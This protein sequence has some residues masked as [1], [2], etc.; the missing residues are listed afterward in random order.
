MSN[1]SKEVYITFNEPDRIWNVMHE[2]VCVFYTSD[3]LEVD[4]WLARN[5]QYVEE[6][7]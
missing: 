6:S 3:P 7:L 1:K 5:T 2:S 4:H